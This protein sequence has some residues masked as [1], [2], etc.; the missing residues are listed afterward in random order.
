MKTKN[1][2]IRAYT[3]KPSSNRTLA[4]YKTRVRLRLSFLILAEYNGEIINSFF[5]PLSTVAVD[6]AN[7]IISPRVRPALLL[8]AN[9]PVISSAQS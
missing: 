8:L 2:E 6:V 7:E 4:E 9:Y 1:D 3:F 5:L